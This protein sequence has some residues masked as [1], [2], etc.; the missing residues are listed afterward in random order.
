M[1][2][3]MHSAARRSSRRRER[4]QSLVEFALMAP[5]FFIMVYGIVDLSRAFQSYVTLQ[6]A[7]RSAARYAVTGRIDCTGPAIQNRDTC[8]RNEATQHTKNLDRHGTIVTTYRSWDYPTYADPPA[9]G[10]AGAQCDAVEVEL[11]YDYHPITPIF[12]FF[13]SNV[14]MDARE[15]LVNEPFGSCS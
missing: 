3:S 9:Q 10:N 4:G 15:R 11:T 14:P 7:A 8:I 5:I 12:G 6:E 1:K 2:T 13:V